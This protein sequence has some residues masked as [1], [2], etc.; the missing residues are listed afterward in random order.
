L[1]EF[2]AG[3]HLVAVFVGPFDHFFCLIGHLLRQ[4][5]DCD[6]A[7]AVGVETLEEPLRAGARR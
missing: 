4:F 5:V 1:D 6:L 3:D 7:I 2:F